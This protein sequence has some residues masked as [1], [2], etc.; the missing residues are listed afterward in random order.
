MGCPL[1]DDTRWRVVER[2]GVR[3]AVRCECWRAV[4]AEHRLTDARIPRRYQHCTLENFVEYPN[5]RLQ[6]ALARARRFAEVFPV[7]DKGLFLIGPPGVGKS[8]LAVAVLRQVITTRGARGL[9]YDV[10]ELLKVIRSTYDPVVRTTEFEV[11]RPVMDAE[12]LVLD[13]LGAEK[14]SEWVEETLNL[15]VTTRY[16]ERRL[17][18]FTSNYE[19]KE[20]RTDPDSL[21]ARVGFRMH[22]RLYEMCEFL[23][24]RR[25][26]LPAPPAQRRSRGSGDDVEGPGTAGCAAATV[27]GPG[28][29]R[30]PAAGP[31]GGCCLARRPGGHGAVAGT[32]VAHGSDLTALSGRSA[33]GAA[34]GLPPPATPLG[35]YLHIPFCAA[36]CNYCHFTRALL[37]PALKRRYVVGLTR[38]IRRAAV[39]WAADT[40]YFGGGTPSL[41]DPG[42]VAGLLSACREAFAVAPGAEITLEVNP[43]TVSRERLAAFREAGVNR[44]SIGVQSFRNEDLRRLD[45]LHDADRARSVVLDA[46]AAGF[47]NISLDL[48]IGL[49]CQHPSDVDLSIDGVID[50]APEHAS[51]YL[52]ELSAGAPL[53]AVT[54]R[55]GWPLPSDDDVADMYLHAMARLEAAGLRQ[56]RD[57]ER[58]PPGPRVAPQPQVLERWGLDW[59]RVRCPLDS[60]ACAM[61][62]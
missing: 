38:E 34:Y 52:L 62:Q 60:R 4:S 43:E 22:S 49:P 16:N 50:L 56:Y 7:A 3:R 11:L 58:G 5:E 13:D 35:L 26:R 45:R 17:T 10:R 1:C 8:H 15:I 40:I 18:I 29:G 32:G 59:V 36:L 53:K 9:F 2:D 48:M 19:E 31:Q 12:L 20:D 24:Y 46:R 28:A 42:E 44:L 61:E 6:R 33:P 57:L 55:E 23:E 37:D 47:E 54:A 25:R 27:P 51:A 21:L 30:A 39:G 14:T 41:L